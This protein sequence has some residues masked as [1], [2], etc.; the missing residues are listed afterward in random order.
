MIIVASVSC[1]YGIGSAETYAQMTVKIKA[2]EKIDRSEL[3]KRFVELRYTRNDTAFYRSTFR[4]RGDVIE[5]FPSHL[6]DRDTQAS[7]VNG[8]RTRRHALL[9]VTASPTAA[10]TRTRR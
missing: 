2:G 4:V 9:R 1:I 6:E 10:G 8:A 3:L 5:I 7:R